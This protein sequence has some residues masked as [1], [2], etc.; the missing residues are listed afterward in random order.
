MDVPNAAIQI[1]RLTKNNV[2]G[3]TFDTLY[4][5]TQ[6]RTQSMLKAG[7]NVVEKWACEFTEEEKETAQD[8]GLD[9]EVSQ[10]VP[11]EAFYG[12][13]TEVVILSSS[14][15]DNKEICYFDVTSEYPFVNA[16]RFY[17]LGH[18]KVLLK[19]QS[20]QDNQELPPRRLLNPLLPLRVNNAL[21][22]PLCTQCCLGK[23][24]S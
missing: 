22:F 3:E 6:R 20:P 8:L 17:P 14:V 11:K 9:E 16:R 18:P 7:Y 24:K 15:D 1:D 2:N 4:V 12:G 5:K 21:L 13:L 10:L 23:R 19:H